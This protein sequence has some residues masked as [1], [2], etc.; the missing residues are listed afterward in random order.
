[1]RNELVNKDGML[2]DAVMYPDRDSKGKN[3]V[4]ERVG[5]E[6]KAVSG[7]GFRI[8]RDGA[9]AVRRLQSRPTTTR[10]CIAASWLT[11]ARRA[12]P[13]RGPPK[14]LFRCFRCSMRVGVCRPILAPRCVLPSLY[15]PL[16]AGKADKFR[17]SLQ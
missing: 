17:P 4:G 9:D 7:G 11:R 10:A 3:E 13:V 5:R 12:A 14:P 8:G 6:R 1:M 15:Q 16:A 2:L